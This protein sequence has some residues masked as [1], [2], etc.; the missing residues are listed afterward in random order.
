M[1]GWM[2]GWFSFLSFFL[3]CTHPP[4]H[5]PQ[6]G[7][8]NHEIKEVIHEETAKPGKDFIDMLKG[9]HEEVKAQKAAGKAGS[10]AADADLEAAKA[11]F[12]ERLIQ[13]FNNK[14]LH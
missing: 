12:K 13:K 4:S 7:D 2:D 10:A 3:F 9:A 5:H 14:T 1:D 6:L 11:A 8:I